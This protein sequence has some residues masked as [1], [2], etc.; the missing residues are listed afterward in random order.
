MKYFGLLLILA[1]TGFAFGRVEVVCD[2]Q[3][4]TARGSYVGAE[5]IRRSVDFI[6]GS[7]LN[8]ATR[9]Y[10]YGAYS[11]YALLWFS[12]TEVAILE[13][14]GFATVSGNF[15]IS[16]VKRI[17]STLGYADFQQIN[18]SSR[19]NYRITCRS[20]GRWIDPLLR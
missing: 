10:A 8:R 5:T 2:V 14:T 4:A 20:F 1:L 18:G 12:Q 15:E 9:S 11:R 7:E 6:T 19:T 13:H 3:R 17:F 16:D